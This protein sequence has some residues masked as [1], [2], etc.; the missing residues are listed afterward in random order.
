MMLL[1][2][3]MLPCRIVMGLCLPKKWFLLQQKS[4]S[5]FRNFSISA[6]LH[7]DNTN[8]R[9]GM[10]GLERDS[11][12]SQSGEE[13]HTYEKNIKDKIL[14]AS[15]PF[16]H[17]HGWTRHALSAGAESVGYAGVAHDLFPKEGAELVLYFCSLCN[18]QLA[19]KLKND[20]EQEG[21][22]QMETQLFIRNAVETRLRM[23]IPYIDKWPQA[24]AI[25]SL[26]TNVPASL[27]NLLTTVDDIWYYAG[28]KSTDFGWYTRRA[29][30]AG[31]YKVTELN[32]VQDKS[33]DFHHTWQ[34]LSRR[35]DDA[36]NLHGLLQQ[37]GEV[38]RV[39]REAASAVLVTARNMIGLNLGR[40]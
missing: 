15:L 10:G 22:K 7:V 20:T 14:A 2:A 34:F 30:L 40:R 18:A 29:G 12:D 28:D 38:P 3:Y 19:E 9:N 27:A 21:Y 25:Q 36:A 17:T 6:R 1:N 16:V 26:P 4:F 35:V 23:I 8:T 11:G 31:L 5:G 37:A 33:E 24:L 13:S 32:L 39:A